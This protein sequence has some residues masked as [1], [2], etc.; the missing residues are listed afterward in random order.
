MTLRH[1]KIF[2]A[3][4]EENSIT[5]AAEKLNLAQPAVSTAVKEL[6]DYYHVKLFDRISK[7]LYLT[8]VGRNLLDYATHIVALFGEMEHNI[9]QRE[10]GTLKIGASMTVGTRLMPEYVSAFRKSHPQANIEVTIGNSDLIE[11]K[12]LRSDIDF[13]IIEGT[14][15]SPNIFCDTYRKDRLAV[16]CG[17]SDPL[18]R[19]ETVTAEQ[20]FSRPLLLREKGSGTRELADSV[21]SS[22]ERTYAPAWDSTSTDALIHACALGLGVSILPYLLVKDEIAK[23]TIAELQVENLRFDRGFHVIY[24][25]NKF[26]TPLAKEFIEMCRKFDAGA[27]QPV[28]EERR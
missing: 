16:V 1:M 27:P 22:C 10:S 17:P 15:H 25:K 21:L 26:L 18:C 7:R 9:R 3:V 23:G 13:A 8:D 11:K 28:E 19:L 24:H 4:C 14:V 5:K 2:V 12:I 20:L 6:E